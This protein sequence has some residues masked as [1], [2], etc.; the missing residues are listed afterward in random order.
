MNP[1]VYLKMGRLLHIISTTEERERFLTAANSHE[2]GEV[3]TLCLVMAYTGCRISEA[4]EL[5]ADKID[6]S[7]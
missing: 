7:G 3:R 5:T 2:R 4:L 1:C 6:L